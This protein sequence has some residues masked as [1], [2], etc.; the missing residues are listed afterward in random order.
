M[1]LRWLRMI[2]AFSRIVPLGLLLVS[3]LVVLG[4]QSLLDLLKVDESSLNER[5]LEILQQ[6]RSGDA[7]SLTLLGK[8]LFSTKR[9]VFGDPDW[10]LA[11]RFFHAAAE[12]GHAPAQ[13]QLGRVFALSRIPSPRQALYWFKL[14]AAANDSAAAYNSGLLLAS[15]HNANDPSAASVAF[16]NRVAADLVTALEYFRLAREHAVAGSQ[17]ETDA[18]QA[19]GVVCDALARL[20]TDAL[21]MRRLWR[22]SSPLPPPAAAAELNRIFSVG[23]EALSSFNSSF[24]ASQGAM[25]PST[26]SLAASVVDSFGLLVDSH[27]ADLSPLQL[28]LLLDA[29]QDMI[30][31]LAGKEGGAGRELVLTIRAARYAEAFALSHYCRGHYAR[32]EEDS[33]CFN[34]AASAAVSFY[35]RGGLIKDA[36]RVF[37]MARSHPDAATH[38]QRLAQTP[39]VYHPGLRAAPWWDAEQFQTARAL[40]ALFS[41]P[42]QLASLQGE[43]TALAAME[44]GGLRKGAGPALD[45]QQKQ[46]EKAEG[47]MQRVFT[48]YIGVG[49]PDEAEAEGAGPWSEYGPLW[50]GVEWHQDRCRVL[51]SLCAA[52]QRPLILAEICGADAVR[53]HAISTDGS[54]S[55]SA[56]IAAA[57]EARCGADTLVTVLRLRP[58]AHIR[59]HCGTTNRRLILH[60]A[61]RGSLGVEFRAGDETC[62][63]GWRGYGGDGNAIVFDDSFEHEVRHKG[64]EDRFI[65]LVVLAH[66]DSEAAKPSH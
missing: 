59:P 61:L 58:G 16:E 44:D 18:T 56:S 41:S 30:G 22:A 38:W 8:T 27:A 53:R 31:P 13:F 42:S 17:T 62:G 12:K 4:Q 9:S 15:G 47:G 19:H 52:L 20:P 14:A 23:V 32:R 65:L 1:A 51:P 66:P 54:A 57:V 46:E 35:R 64:K 26:L 25:R 10:E 33:A 5:Q 50:D 3:C 36:E 11:A 39:R 28:H 55:S 60:F 6:A 43:L 21:S 37:E 45:Q 2:G 24:A 49:S 29:L 7:A 40:K 63:G 48:P 34:G